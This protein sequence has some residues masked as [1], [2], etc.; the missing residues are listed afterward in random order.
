VSAVDTLTTLVIAD[1][2]GFNLGGPLRELDLFGSRLGLLAGGG[3]LLFG[4][5]AGAVNAA[6][7]M[8][9]LRIGF[10]TLLGSADAA[11]K[12]LRE[13]QDFA[14]RTPFSLTDIA[15]ASQQLLGAGLGAERLIPVEQALGNIISANGRS[16]EDFAGAL[17]QVSQIISSGKLQGDELRIL[18]ERGLSIRGEMKALGV[19]TGASAEEFLQALVKIGN[20]A[21]YAGAMER[22]SKSLFGSISNLADA[23]V[24]FAAAVGEP[25]IGP[26]TALTQG[27]TS[28]TDAVTKLPAPLKVGL[29]GALLFVAAA[30][31]RAALAARAHAAAERE[32]GIAAATSLGPWQR[33]KASGVFAAGAPAGFLGRGG[34]AGLGLGMLATA[35]GIG[36][37]AASGH[38][39][40]GGLFGDVLTGAG[41]GAMLGSIFPGVG[42]AL[43]AGIG[44]AGGGLFSVLSGQ[45]EAKAGDPAQAEMKRHNDLLEESNRLAKDRLEGERSLRSG[46]AVDT[47]V[48]SVFH[49][50]ILAGYADALK[51]QT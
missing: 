23:G 25:I 10:T 32:V 29:G 2:R 35:G 19:E 38:K 7:R 43:G 26:L 21:K 15:S 51:F 4:L 46:N 24:R 44:A 41:T 30:H 3:G 5:G 6:G 28:L 50:R 36:I 1:T 39:G 22:Q 17:L 47:K 16:S 20:S 40:A 33:L 49:Q 12:K 45:G 13:M 37:S 31:V 9:Q 8:E 34:G 18:T 42:T 48:L 27:L 11:D 14:A